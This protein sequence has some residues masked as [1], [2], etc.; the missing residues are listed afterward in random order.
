MR[1]AAIGLGLIVAMS[2]AGIAVAQTD[3]PEAR[4]QA[5]ER[6]FAEVSMREVLTDMVKEVSKQL[7]AER[8]SMFEDLLLKNLRLDVVEAAA[9]Q[10]LA[11]HLTVVEMDTLTEFM[12]RPEGKSAMGKM[13]FYMADLMPV[14]QT[15]MMRAVKLAQPEQQ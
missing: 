11:R 12:R 10:S 3:T 8:R 9:K 4:T 15:E 14:I 5:V 6:Y 2:C 7:P 1:L 13:K